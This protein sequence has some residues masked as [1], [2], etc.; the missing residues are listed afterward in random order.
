MSDLEDQLAADL[1]E[2]RRD[3]DALLAFATRAIAESTVACRLGSQHVKLFAPNLEKRIRLQ[4][5]PKGAVEVWVLREDGRYQFQADSSGKVV[6]A[7]LDDLADEFAS[8]FADV[9]SGQSKGEP[10]KTAGSLDGLSSSELAQRNAE[11]L[12]ER[13]A[14]AINPLSDDERAELMAVNPFAKATLN[15]TAQMKVIRRDP[16]FADKLKA[17]AA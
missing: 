15:L 16:D 9:I 1:T 7:T 4:S 17:A 13:R 3:H 14:T 8:E 6:P 10:T 11:I 5:T 12:R 2:L